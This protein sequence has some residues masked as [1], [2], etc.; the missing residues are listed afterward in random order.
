MTY[1]PAGRG[2]LTAQEVSILMKEELSLELGL[3]TAGYFDADRDDATMA[4]SHRIYGEAYRIAADNQGDFRLPAG[5]RKRL[6]EADWPARD[7]EAV[8][9]VLTYYCSSATAE[10]EQRLRDLGLTPTAG[11]V[12]QARL[13]LLRARAE[14]Q[15][16]AAAFPLLEA[17]GVF[18]PLGALL[19]NSTAKPP[20]APAALTTVMV[21]ASPVADSAGTCPF[22]SNDQR[23][24]SE[25]AN[26]ICE[27]LIAKKV[28]RAPATQQKRIVKSFVWITGDKVI[29]DYRQEDAASFKRELA[30]LPVTFRWKHKPGALFEDVRK[31]LPALKDADRRNPKTV[32]RDLST[33]STFYAAMVEAGPWKP[34]VQDLKVLDFAK[35]QDSIE[36][37][38]EAP[39]RVP[40]QEKHLLEI[41]NSPI[42]QGNL[43]AKKRLL[44]GSE[45]PQDGAYWAPLLIYW[46]LGTRE[47]ICGLE[48]EDIYLDEP[49]PYIFIR[50]NST[51]DLKRKAR[52]R[53][54]PIH[55][56]LR[57]LGFYQYVAE[58][59]AQK[60]KNLFPELYV[61]EA[62]VGGA[63]FYAVCWVPLM[64]WLSDRME[65][66]ATDAGKEAD[67]HS[68]RTFGASIL[69]RPNINQNVV[70]DLMGHARSSVTSKNYQK[71]RL[72]V[73]EPATLAD[74]M[75]LLDRLPVLTSV[76]PA[77]SPM[78]LSMAQRSRCCSSRPRKI[79]SAKAVTNS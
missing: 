43:G 23:R 38:E 52:K 67:V 39:P 21:G 18:D 78:L 49:M 17:S 65:I 72:V 4:R 59:R 7:I 11:L 29:A 22:I 33:M 69:D 31:G 37:N 74:L 40:W 45:I 58:L 64:N 42:Y 55:P 9:I 3:A 73:D 54:V 5:D 63:Q 75:E 77:V 30:S 46:T 48:L 57:R 56:E 15:D 34:S 60:Q 14:G 16:R 1:Q 61:N 71:R 44:S 26:L 8:R 24:L 76:I 36:E 53:R 68:M 10:I 66:P 51:R 70:K 27:D 19:Q 6:A 20:M 13:H 50:K 41:F 2:V 62:K 25:V 35:L 12:A 79:R 32:N 47:E 28:W